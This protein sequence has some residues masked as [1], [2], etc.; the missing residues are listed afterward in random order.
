VRR[1]SLICGEGKTGTAIMTMLQ[2]IPPFYLIIFLQNTQQRSPLLPY[3]IDLAPPNIFLFPKLK[4][5]MRG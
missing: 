1:K 5:I 2:C 4:F 3:S